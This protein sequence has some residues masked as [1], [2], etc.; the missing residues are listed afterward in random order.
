MNELDLRIALHR[1]A[2]L[3]GEPAPDLLDQL[4][5]R[6]DK[7][8]RHRAGMLATALAVA[9]IG[10]GIPVGQSLLAQPDRSPV[11]QAPVTSTQSVDPTPA[12]TPEPSPTIAP[13]GTVV[14]DPPPVPEDAIPSATQQATILVADEYAFL[15]PSGNINCGISRVGAVCEVK[16][17]TYQPPAKPSDCD[18]DYGTM[19]SVRRGARA[20]FSCHGDTGFGFPAPVLA[21]GE[22]VSNGIVTCVSATS[23]MSCSTVSGSHGFELSRGSYRLY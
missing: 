15:S 10:A 14:V 5:V 16:N 23:G 19:V 4:A 1:D 2:D 18:L 6:R 11:D 20:E 12:R 3:V 13:S 22:R 9:V 8:R 17:E 7:Q 21:Y